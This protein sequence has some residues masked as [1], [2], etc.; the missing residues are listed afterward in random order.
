MLL[1]VAHCQV[2]RPVDSFLLSLYGAVSHEAGRQ[3]WRIVPRPKLDL[4]LPKIA[5]KANFFNYF[6][7]FRKFSTSYGS[8]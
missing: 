5:L 8:F 4:C 1:V 2:D 3:A 7:F 6:W